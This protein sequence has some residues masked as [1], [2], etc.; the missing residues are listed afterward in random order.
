MGKAGGKFQTD[1]GWSGRGGL[2]TGKRLTKKKS[3]VPRGG[4]A[5]TGGREEKGKKG[6]QLLEEREM[7]DK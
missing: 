2:T 3:H 1:P 4:D 5:G 7:G 6:F